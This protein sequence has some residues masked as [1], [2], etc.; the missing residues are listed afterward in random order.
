MPDVAARTDHPVVELE[1]HQ[2]TSELR[3][4]LRRM[5]GNPTTILGLILVLLAISC[6]VFAPL[7]APYDPVVGDLRQYVQ[8]PSAAHLFGTDD[9]GRD[10][11]S[12]VVFGAQI[13]IKLALAV[14]GLTLMVGLCS[15]WSAASTAAGSTPSSCA[16]PT[17]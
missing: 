2:Q 6:A 15:A 5:I 17:S 8:P 16:S 11:F 10:V 12:R 9:I 4:A 14:Q 1:V 7:I 13:S 3:R